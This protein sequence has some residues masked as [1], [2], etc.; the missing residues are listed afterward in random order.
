MNRF[1]FE[2]SK[3][4]KQQIAANEDIKFLRGQHQADLD[5]ALAR[6]GE[7]ETNGALACFENYEKYFQQDCLDT[8]YEIVNRANAIFNVALAAEDF[9]DFIRL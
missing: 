6:Y 8:V 4:I 7:F 9:V 3:Y 1:E 5:A 2:A